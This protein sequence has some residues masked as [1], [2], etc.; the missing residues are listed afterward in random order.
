MLPGTA[1]DKS[2]SAIRA[3]IADAV[4]GYDSNRAVRAAAGTVA[5]LPD[6]SFGSGC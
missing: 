2:P 6:A 1:N 3:E 5:G 4:A